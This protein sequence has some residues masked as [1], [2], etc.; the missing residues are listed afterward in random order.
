M[1]MLS[2]YIALNLRYIYSKA[3]YRN[4]TIETDM[5]RP[6]GPFTRARVGSPT[7]VNPSTNK[8]L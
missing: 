2:I 3:L 4:Y 1:L 5:N 6:R 8:I 7:R